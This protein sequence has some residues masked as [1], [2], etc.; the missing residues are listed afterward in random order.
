MTPPL[1]LLGVSRSGTTLLRVILDRSPGIA[2]PDESFFV[3]LL[4]RRHRGRV[5][6]PCFLDDLSRIPAL[7]EWGL[8]PGD[9]EPLLR[10]EMSASDA[11]AAIFDAYAAKAGKP[12]WGDKTPMYM[13]H[14]PLLERLFPD[15]QY[16]HLI[17]DGRDAAVSFLQMPEG[18]FTRTWAHPESAAEFACLWRIEVEGAREL[19][20]RAGPTRYLEARYEE[21]VSDPASTV[22]SI[23]AFAGIPFESAMLDYHGVVDVAAKPHQQR[24]LEPPTTGVRDWRSELEPEDARSFEATAG[25]LLAELGYPLLDPP[26]RDPGTRAEARLAWYRTR[27]AAWNASAAMVQRSPLWRRRHPRLTTPAA[28]SGRRA[29]ERRSSAR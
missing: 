23:C 19:G 27:L 24:L 2:V 8:A 15:A 3:P 18:T 11:I 17:R 22:R 21:L 14:L 10:S 6:V 29:P 28:T 4:A 12:R 1:I 7:V 13:R 20:E 25:G 9:V 26:G 16:V 5:D